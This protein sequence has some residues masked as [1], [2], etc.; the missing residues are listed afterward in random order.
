MQSSV[1]IDSLCSLKNVLLEVQIPEFRYVDNRIY[2]VR[3]KMAEANF[4][5]YWKMMDFESFYVF[6]F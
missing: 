2:K 6:M 4:V 1:V 5:M 3:E